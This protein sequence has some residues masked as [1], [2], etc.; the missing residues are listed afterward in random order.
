[1]I[2]SDLGFNK[3][4]VYRVM[5]AL[6]KKGLVSVDKTPGQKNQY[7]PTSDTE[8]LVTESHQCQKVTGVV[9]E[10]HQVVTESHQHP[11]NT[12]EQD[13]KTRL[14]SLSRNER[15]QASRR[16]AEESLD[17]L[18][19]TKYEEKYPKLNISSEFQKC[20]DYHLSKQANFHGPKRYT[21]WGRVLHTWFR[22]ATERIDARASPKPKRFMP[23]DFYAKGD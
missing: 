11:N 19:L 1:M 9:T 2:G 8:S 21:D 7:R 4:T 20:K 23:E 17:A 16:K 14:T 10:S 3:R 13:T 22:N 12:Q 6:E 18:D 5:A 15:I